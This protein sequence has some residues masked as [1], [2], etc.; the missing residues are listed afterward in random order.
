MGI[1]IVLS[2]VSFRSNYW[3]LKR[4]WVASISLV[5]LAFV[6][7]GYKI[8]K[9]FAKINIILAFSWIMLCFTPIVLQFHKVAI[10][11]SQALRE[12]LDQISVISKEEQNNFEYLESLEYFETPKNLQNQNVDDSNQYWVS[13]ANKNIQQGGKVWKGFRGFYGHPK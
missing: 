12:R 10:S 8:S 7:L 4:Q 9:I 2:Y 11:N 5:P 6:W 13:L 1:S 3:I